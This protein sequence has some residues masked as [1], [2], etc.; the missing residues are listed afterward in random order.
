[1]YALK[2]YALSLGCG[3]SKQYLQGHFF[4]VPAVL[5]GDCREMA[6]TEGREESLIPSYS[7][8]AL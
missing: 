4:N 1:M 5:N 2:T 8:A 7:C 6:P 3:S